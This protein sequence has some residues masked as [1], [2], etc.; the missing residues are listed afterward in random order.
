MVLTSI[1]LEGGYTLVD[2]V[3]LCL[4][5]PRKVVE[6]DSSGRSTTKYCSV[7][8]FRL[9][10]D[11]SVA[12]V[13]AGRWMGKNT[14]DDELTLMPFVSSEAVD[15]FLSKLCSGNS[16]A[17]SKSFSTLSNEDWDSRF[18]AQASSSNKLFFSILC[19]WLPCGNNTAVSKLSEHFGRQKL[20]GNLVCLPRLTIQVL[21]EFL[22]FQVLSTWKNWLPHNKSWFLV[23]WAVHLFSA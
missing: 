11:S 18:S 23:H 15:I 13:G 5:S 2:H 17:G 7:S 19:D 20:T 12:F 3:T 4:A 1:P 6:K 9:P 16:G 22:C 10:S 8:C 21:I 14:F